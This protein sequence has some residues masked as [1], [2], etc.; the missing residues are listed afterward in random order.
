M[1]QSLG[2][3]SDAGSGGLSVK[4]GVNCKPWDLRK[5]SFG[6]KGSILTNLFRREVYGS[7]LHKLAN[8]F[9]EY[10]TPTRLRMPI[11]EVIPPSALEAGNIF[12]GF[13]NC[14]RYILSYTCRPSENFGS[15]FDSDGTYMYTLHIWLFKPYSKVRKVS[16][17]CLFDNNGVYDNNL[18]IDICQWEMDDSHLLI[19]GHSANPDTE[20]H[21]TFYT[22]ITT[23]P[24]ARNCPNC[25]YIQDDELDDESRT[26]TNCILHGLTIHMKYDH[27]PPFPKMNADVQLRFK[28]AVLLN[29]GNVIHVVSFRLLRPCPPKM[30]TAVV[31]AAASAIVSTTRFPLRCDIWLKIP[32][33]NLLAL[34]SVKVNAQGYEGGKT[35]EENIISLNALDSLSRFFPAST[36]TKPQN[37]NLQDALS[38]PHR[39]LS[40]SSTDSEFSLFSPKS[41]TGCDFGPM[42]PPF[43]NKPRSPRR[44][45]SSSSGQNQNMNI[46]PSKLM[47]PPQERKFFKR[48]LSS[49][50]LT[51]GI[52][53]VSTETLQSPT[54]SIEEVAQSDSTQ[55]QQNQSAFD[56]F[57]MR[58]ED[59]AVERHLS[60]FKTFRKRRLADK[61]YEFNDA[62][63]SAENII[64]LK[65]T[66]RKSKYSLQGNAMNFS[67]PRSPRNENVAAGGNESPRGSYSELSHPK[68]PRAHYIMS[69]VMSPNYMNDSSVSDVLRPLNNNS[70]VKVS[71]LSPNSNLNSFDASEV[72]KV[73]EEDLDKDVSSHALLQGPKKVDIVDIP[74]H[75]HAK[76]TISVHVNCVAKVLRSYIQKE[77]DN[78]SVITDIEDEQYQ[79]YPF[80]VAL[81][82]EVHGAGYQQLQMI[83]NSKADKFQVPVVQVLQRTLD[84]EML[85]NEV[86]NLIC[87]ASDK[88]YCSCI[89]FDLAFAE[90][91]PDRGTVTSIVV[92]LVQ[93]TSI[94]QRNRGEKVNH[95]AYYNGRMKYEAFFCC[96]W[97]P[98]REHCRILY[99]SNLQE[100]ETV[101]DPWHPTENM[102]SIIKCH[103]ST[104]LPTKKTLSNALAV[105]D[106]Q[107]LDELV[108]ASGIV[109]LFKDEGSTL[110]TERRL[111]DFNSVMF[112]TN[113]DLASTTTDSDDEWGM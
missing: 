64:P 43:L 22:T 33:A 28:D 30:E 63:H 52:N 46:S 98:N 97:V 7:S 24:D 3:P 20:C 79:G 31:P 66:R 19:T 60:S 21:H 68:S 72:S 92:M 12:M 32:N 78:M 58:L 57:E 109:T 45:E 76:P 59:T 62:D 104:L 14:G 70:K 84:I 4:G 83:S 55:S 111:N 101:P 112:E 108:D 25:V 91:N 50:N 1:F 77:D 56:V 102:E 48:R 5:G 94:K 87:L 86:A 47:L 73:K 34:A 107:S 11:E 96:E 100:L 36:S 10:G 67:N 26:R 93:A 106:W 90:A 105:H 18:L 74:S 103:L 13:T 8:P 23:I 40:Q 80:P 29:T 54:K 89:D 88:H 6:N 95:L 39:R 42:S 110:K 37:Q 71:A 113:V 41:F 51:S 99:K 2:S 35:V 65:M 53:E 75:P 38:R 16:Q 27:V 82:L 61:K 9:G 44:N 85:C 17:V 69:P 81:P 15:V 49:Q